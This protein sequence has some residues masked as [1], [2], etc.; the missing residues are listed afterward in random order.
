M[1]QIFEDLTVD[2]I[3]KSQDDWKKLKEF[4]QD[5]YFQNSYVNN[6]RALHELQVQ[7]GTS[8]IDVPHMLDCDS[9]RKPIANRVI[10]NIAQRTAVAWFIDG[11]QSDLDYLWKTL[12]YFC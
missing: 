1:S 12:E 6:K 8:V 2:Y 7:A 5:P 9:P 4:L 10:K 3:Y 11:Q